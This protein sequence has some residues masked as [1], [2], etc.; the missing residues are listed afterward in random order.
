MFKIYVK[1]GLHS[2]PQSGEVCSKMHPVYKALANINA[3][4]TSEDMYKKL[5]S[6]DGRVYIKWVM[7]D[8]KKGGG[9]GGVPKLS[10]ELVKQRPGYTS[11][12]NLLDAAHMIPMEKPN[13]MACKITDTIQVIFG[14]SARM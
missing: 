6:L 9:I 10:T 5:P 13:E 2:D 1:S 4:E 7:P 12:I 3:K 14:T 11:C 8:P